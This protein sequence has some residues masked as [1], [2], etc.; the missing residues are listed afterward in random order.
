MNA[1]QLLETHSEVLASAAR[2]A[3]VLVLPQ[4]IALET[5][6]PHD[7]EAPGRAKEEGPAKQC[8]GH[9]RLK[10]ADGYLNQNGVVY[11]THTRFQVHGTLNIS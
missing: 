4:G 8:G 3:G 7:S 10:V 11:Y 2:P 1:R 9:W 5:V 6:E